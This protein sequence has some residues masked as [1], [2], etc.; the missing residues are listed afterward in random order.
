MTNWYT[1]E[2]EAEFRRR[3]WEREIEAQARAAQARSATPKRTWHWPDFSRL[4]P[5][6]L[7]TAVGATRASPAPRHG[8]ATGLQHPLSAH[9]GTGRLALTSTLESD[10]LTPV[11]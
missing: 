11:C 7:L 8:D 1:I 2:I 5:A 9:R 3:E 6:N 4:S 10:C